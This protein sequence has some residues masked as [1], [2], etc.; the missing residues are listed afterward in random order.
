[1]PRLALYN[2]GTLSVGGCA[3]P[4]LAVKEGTRVLHDLSMTL[5]VE[6]YTH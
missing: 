1:L 3:H 4:E 5:S 2:N 6:R